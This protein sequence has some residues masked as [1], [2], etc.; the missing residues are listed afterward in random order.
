MTVLS[1]VA[2][3]V[4]RAVPIGEQKNKLICV[5]R[6][7]KKTFLSVTVISVKYVL[8]VVIPT[9]TTTKKG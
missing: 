1:L 4:W 9:T 5:Q 8:P 6:K 7:K 3:V 2:D